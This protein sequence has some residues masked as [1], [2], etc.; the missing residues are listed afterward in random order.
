MSQRKSCTTAK[1]RCD[2]CCFSTYVTS[3]GR[4]ALICR[5]KKAP[6]PAYISCNNKTYHLGYFTDEIEAAH[7]YDKAA[8][9]YHGR[10][11]SLNLPGMDISGASFRD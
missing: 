4:T 1:P 11:A 5:Q 10:F 8:K 2:N 3:S 9:R 7:A 6:K